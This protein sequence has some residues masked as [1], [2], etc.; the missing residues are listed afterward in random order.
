MVRRAKWDCFAIAAFL[1]ESAFSYMRCLNRPT[2]IEI[3]TPRIRARHIETHRTGLRMYPRE[4]FRILQWAAARLTGTALP[5]RRSQ[6]EHYSATAL[7]LP[8][9][10]AAGAAKRPF[11]SFNRAYSLTVSN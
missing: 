9:P 8:E 6:W 4:I 2:L 11:R 3:Y 10:F 7:S 1:P 5:Y